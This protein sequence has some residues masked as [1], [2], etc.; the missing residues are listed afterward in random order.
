[1]GEAGTKWLLYVALGELVVGSAQPASVDLAFLVKARLLAVLLPCP[2]CPPCQFLSRILA[3]S[4]PRVKGM[5]VRDRDRLLS[6]FACGR[7]LFSVDN[8]A[9]CRMG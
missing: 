8:P 3:G 2:M 9:G 7:H 4:R 1:M 6:G 5:L